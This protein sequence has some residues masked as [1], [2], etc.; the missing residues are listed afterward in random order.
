MKKAI[1][2]ETIK[3]QNIKM[4]RLPNVFQKNPKENKL[5]EPLALVKEN[6]HSKLQK[7]FFIPSSP[8]NDNCEYQ[9]NGPNDRTQIRIYLEQNKHPKQ[10][11]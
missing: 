9:S 3:P 7:I 11:Q 1:G 4:Q 2:Y 8:S 10:Q 6:W 5:S